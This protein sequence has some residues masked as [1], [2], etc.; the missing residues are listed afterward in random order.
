MYFV[1]WAI[2]FALITKGYVGKDVD[3]VFIITSRQSN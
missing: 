1:S 3:T 2:L